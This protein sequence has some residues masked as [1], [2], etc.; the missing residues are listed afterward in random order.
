MEMYEELG[1]EFVAS[2][3]IHA[4]ILIHVF[5]TF[6]FYFSLSSILASR[7]GEAGISPLGL[8]LGALAP[9]VIVGL[10]FMLL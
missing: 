10:A 4:N 1:A 9:T 2:H 7:F 5:T 8:F 3:Q 6:G